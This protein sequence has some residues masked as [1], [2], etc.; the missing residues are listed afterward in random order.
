MTR[1]SLRFVGVSPTNYYCLSRAENVVSVKKN[2]RSKRVKL[3]IEQKTLGTKRTH[4]EWQID[5]A[6]YQ[7][8]GP[9]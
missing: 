6:I 5:N 3:E 1:R 7:T 2:S 8:R 9:E 4:E